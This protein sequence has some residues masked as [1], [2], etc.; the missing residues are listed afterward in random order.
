M[1]LISAKQRDQRL[2]PSSSCSW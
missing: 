1:I 2:K